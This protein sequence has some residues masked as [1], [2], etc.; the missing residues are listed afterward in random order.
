MI[1][2]GK[3][4]VCKD[5]VAR[6]GATTGSGQEI[7]CSRCGDA[8]GME[9]SRFGAALGFT[10]CTL[11][12]LAP[13]DFSRAVAFCTYDNEM[14]EMLHLL[15]FDGQRHIAEHVLGRRMAEAV[16]KLRPQAAS[17]LIVI[18]VP[19]FA[20]HERQRGFNQA[21][22]LAQAALKRLR[23]AEPAWNLRILPRV[24]SR[25]R[26]THALYR[27]N[28]SQRR[29][30]L[31]G[32]FRVLDKAAILGR[33]VLLIDDIMTTGATARECSRVLLAAGAA[34]VWVAT[35]ARAQP[36]SSQ[37]ISQHETS[38]ARWDATPSRK[39]IEPDVGRRKTF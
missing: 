4:R 27:L 33:E 26:D 14:R 20:A 12:R 6:V 35:A 13:P 5:C 29:A 7:L 31:R 15:K 16:L 23:D 19:L 32:A 22:L 39:P 24:L 10:E 2:F 11:C 17:D 18:P 38:V 9:S 25:V 28:P 34:K 30:N 37:N 36:E 8:L 3:V 1:A 21:M